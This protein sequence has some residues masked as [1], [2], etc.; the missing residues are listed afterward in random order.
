M[1]ILDELKQN[2][3]L[4]SDGAWGTLLQ[5][6]GMQPGECP[7]L[8]NITHRRDVLEVAQSYLQ[9]GS[10]IIETNSLGG[11]RLK[12]SQYGLGDRVSEINLA[13]ALIS[14]EAAGSD[15]HVAGSVGP[16]GKLLLMGDVTEA[17]LY[18]GFC[19]Q[20]IALEKGGADIII[21]ETMS[22][23]DEASLAVKA[24][25]ENTHCT[26]IITMSFSKDMKGEYFTMMGVSPL[27]MVI[28]TK[29][30]GA[31][32]VGSNCGNGIEE[33]IGIVRAIRAAD[34]KIPV[35]IQAN[36]GTPELIDGKTVYHDSPGFMASFVPEL[37]KAGAN[38]IGGCCGTTP[39]HIKEMRRI[40]GP[41][42]SV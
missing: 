27:E 8:W 7:E 20:S 31:H 41:L 19:E 26:V 33:M 18:D 42:P 40:L 16:T 30:A 3:I 22:A 36:A 37:I 11:S 32:A 4:L 29:E 2:K 24:A 39:E 10:D 28:S 5:S 34:N 14:R 23:L 21:I 35:I 25:R 17:E 12:L 13:A 6:K 9:A 38:I 15:N 1:N